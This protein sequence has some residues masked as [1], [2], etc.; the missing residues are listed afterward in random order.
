M[1]H[2]RYGKLHKY[3]TK[4]CRTVLNIA[5]V[6]KA[7]SVVHIGTMSVYYGSLLPGCSQDLLS[8][9]TPIP[10]VANIF[11]T[12]TKSFSLPDNHRSN[13]S[14]NLSPKLS[15]E[16]PG[17]FHT[18]SCGSADTL[19][20]SQQRKMTGTKGNQKLPPQKKAPASPPR[21]KNTPIP[22]RKKKETNILQVEAFP[23]PFS[24]EKYIYMKGE[25]DEKDGFTNNFKLF[26]EDKLEDKQPQSLVKANVTALLQRRI[27]N[28][29]NQ[30]WKDASNYHR[31]III[32]YPP[33]RES[34][35]QTRQTGLDLIAEF[36][37]DGNYS[38][39]PPDTIA[40]VDITDLDNSPPLDSFFMDKDIKDFMKQDLPEN[41]LDEHF[42]ETYPEFAK[43][44]W[45][46]NHLSDFAKGLGFS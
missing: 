43:Q 21:R 10:P 28:T 25:D 7:F 30:V 11:S 13:D 9:L 27:P 12:E 2:T 26:V 31:H 22:K 40:K 3:R 14:Q 34:T 17:N 44:C 8:L 35:V 19:S 39:F 46:G 37:Q 20:V 29:D 15:P 36:C 41:E 38:R 5:T 45:S 24:F 16:G 18:I 32:R 42:V 4:R 1:H 23:E 6:A 33:E